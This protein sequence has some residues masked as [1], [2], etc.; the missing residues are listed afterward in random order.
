MSS[1]MTTIAV[2]RSLRGRLVAA[3]TI[4]VLLMA[5]GGCS[6]IRAVAT[7]DVG[8]RVEGNINANV[9]AHLPPVQSD[10][11]V[12]PL[13]LPREADDPHARR[14]AVVDVDGLLVNDDLTGL[15]SMGDNPVS[16]FRE[17]LDAVA[18]DKRVAAVVVRINS[19]G[20]GVTACDIMRHDLRT[21]AERTQ[22][23]IVACI[24]DVGTGGAY[25][26]ATAADRIVAHPT[27]IV[28]GI[29]VILNLYNLQD[30]MAQLNVVATPIKSGKHIDLGSPVAELHEEQAKLLQ[31]MADK[32][33][34]RFR[35]AVV[36]DRPGVDTEDE[37]LYDGRVFVADDAFQRR[38]IDEVGYLNNAVNLAA[39]AAGCGPVVVTFYHRP[40]DRP[41]S[42]YSRTPNVPLQNSLIPL[43]LPG[44][45]RSRL[46]SF[47]YLWQ[48]E[49]TME[50]LSGR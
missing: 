17:R 3:G 6:P 34:R 11:P 1:G 18:A 27:S 45:D 43:S 2:A 37:T 50:R 15:G 31:A 48:P 49:P 40:Q 28:G 36:H 21:F 25:Y 32:F 4:V 13:A 44:L 19:H 38:L 5:L 24:M 23:P 16:L 20:G 22:L 41:Q 39:V 46:P 14:I 26:L 8:A 30:A 29:G 35:E 9:N 33:H 42:L 7:A 12:M 10:H 47:L